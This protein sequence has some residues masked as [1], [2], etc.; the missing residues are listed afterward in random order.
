MLRLWLGLKL[1]ESGKCNVVKCKQQMCQ[2]GHHGLACRAGGDMVI[3]HNRIRDCIFN[4]A[5][6]GALAPA[7]EKYGLLTDEPESR[8][9]DVFIPSIKNQSN[10]CLDVAV[11][12]P[13]KG[14]YKREIE[15][16]NKYA[17]EI[18]LRRYEHSFKGGNLIYVPVVFDTFGGLNDMGKNI[19]D[20]IMDEC[21]GRQ[22]GVSKNSLWRKV[23]H[24]LFYS[25]VCMILR[26]VVHP[27]FD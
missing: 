19:L 1:S 17:E 18:K 21:V 8:P 14:T 4:I 24:C 3:R 26:R 5:R 20:S 10:V 11:T 27:T 6:N 15:A 7:K 13:F 12:C 22:E 23:M 2:M 16:C 9:A 25:N